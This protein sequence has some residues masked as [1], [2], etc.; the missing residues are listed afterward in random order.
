M[1]QYNLFLK[2]SEPGVKRAGRDEYLSS[3]SQEKRAHLSFL[4]VMG[5]FTAHPSWGQQ[6]TLLS[7]PIQM[8]ISLETRLQTYLEMMLNQI[9][10]NPMIQSLCHIK[11]NYLSQI[12]N[13]SQQKSESLINSLLYAE[14]PPTAKNIGSQMTQAKAEKPCPSD[15]SFHPRLIKTQCQLGNSICFLENAIAYLTSFVQLQLIYCWLGTLS[16]F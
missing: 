1:I 16:T 15:D 12:G 4:H 8:Q 7:P 11:I 3:I 10:G 6:S 13:A 9:S 5:L 14:Q 2:A